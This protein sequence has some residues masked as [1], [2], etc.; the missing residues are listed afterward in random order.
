MYTMFEC[1]GLIW[2]ISLHLDF[3]SEDHINF[4][5][6]EDFFGFGASCIL[7][8]FAVI[9]LWIF[10]F[11]LIVQYYYKE[12]DVEWMQRTKLLAKSGGVCWLL[13]MITWT[14]TVLFI[15]LDDWLLKMAL[16]LVPSWNKS[17]LIGLLYSIFH[18][19]KASSSRTIRVVRYLSIVTTFLSVYVGVLSIGCAFSWL[20]WVLAV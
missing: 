19:F 11:R 9:F 15:S 13:A 20:F 12:Q 3:E 4:F 18:E 1:H 10:A 8:L 16:A 6:D 17:L 14:V 2:I 5:A 7:C